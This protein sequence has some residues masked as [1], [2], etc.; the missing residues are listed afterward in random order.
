MAES[1]KQ[2]NVGC[3]FYKYDDGKNR[4]TCEGLLGMSNS[5]IILSF[6]RRKDFE[7]QQNGYC[8]D[9]YR[10]CSIYKMLMKKYEKK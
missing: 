4:I 1:F 6:R 5:S 7:T 2:A 9:K 8:C 10:E 3:P